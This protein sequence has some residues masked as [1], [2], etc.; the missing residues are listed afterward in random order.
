MTRYRLQFGRR[1][2]GGYCP[3]RGSCTRVRFHLPALYRHHWILVF[4]AQNPTSRIPSSG[5]PVSDP[6]N[7]SSATVST[8]R[9][10]GYNKGLVLGFDYVK[11]SFLRMIAR[12]LGLCVM[13][14]I[15]LLE[16]NRIWTFWQS[17]IYV[18][19]RKFKENPSIVS[20]AVLADKRT[21]RQA[22]G[23]GEANK[24][25]SG[26]CNRCWKGSFVWKS[27]AFERTV[28]GHV[29]L[30]CGPWVCNDRVQ[31][32]KDRER[33]V[34]WLWCELLRYCGVGWWSIALVEW[35][36]PCHGSGV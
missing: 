8:Y 19:N 12:K 24:R 16:F 11:V 36:G 15:L 7:S 35:Q 31:R 21:D 23:H 14:P 22:V 27:C 30:C 25:F 28:I 17:L 26:L 3:R 13:F 6:A 10:C 18:P 32:E 20:R 2:R 33:V 9:S 1:F 34:F 4:L 5:H 29:C